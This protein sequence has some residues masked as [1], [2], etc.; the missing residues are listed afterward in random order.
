MKIWTLFKRIYYKWGGYNCSFA[1]TALERDIIT[2]VASQLP[3]KDAA[4][5]LSQ[6]DNFEYI[7]R[8]HKGRIIAFGFG[9]YR[10]ALL[11]RSDLQFCLTEVKLRE[12]NKSIIPNVICYSGRLGAI[13]Y[14]RVLGSSMT[15]D[16][17]V[18]LPEKYVDVEDAVHRSAHGK[19]GV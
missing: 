16:G 12:A 11:W 15:I 8:L 4:V 10:G 9:R 13:Q 14:R 2:A 5:L 6:L 19:E 7:Q 17:V 18:L 1:A 3:E